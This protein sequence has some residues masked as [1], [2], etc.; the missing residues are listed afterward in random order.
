MNIMWL[1]MIIMFL[2][3]AGAF[4]ADS[5]KAALASDIETGKICLNT[6]AE[7]WIKR[8]DYELNRAHCGRG[9]CK[10]EYDFTSKSDKDLFEA[11]IAKVSYER[12][13]LE[14]EIRGC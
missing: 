4:D 9:I 1:I 6:E 3:I 13:R 11:F 12:A 8:G 10:D 2:S 7:N 14:M 5:E